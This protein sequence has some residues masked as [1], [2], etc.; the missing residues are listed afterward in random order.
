MCDAGEKRKKGGAEKVWEKKKKRLMEPIYLEYCFKFLIL[1]YKSWTFILT[2]KYL[3]NFKFN[4][5]CRNSNLKS[6]KKK[7]VALYF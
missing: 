4:T 6:S 7:I 2:T 1:R 3:L 5:F